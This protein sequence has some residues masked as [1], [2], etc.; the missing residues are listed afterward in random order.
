M[1]VGALVS[2]DSSTGTGI[3]D[4]FLASNCQDQRPSA[5][6][7]GLGRWDQFISLGPT[8]DQN[9]PFYGPIQWVKRRKDNRIIVSYGAGDGNRTHVRSLGRFG[10]NQY[11]QKTNGLQQTGGHIAGSAERVLLSES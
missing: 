1:F 10:R 8:W 2:T 6:N 5:S 7:F 3:Y 4:N 11:H 9:P